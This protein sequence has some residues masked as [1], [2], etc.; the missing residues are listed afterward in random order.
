MRPETKEWLALMGKTLLLVVGGV[1]AVAAL[2]DLVVAGW[3]L[4]AA[5]YLLAGLLLC[6]PPIAFAFRD[7]VR[8]ARRGSNP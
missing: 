7:A 1:V 3:T 6:I 4:V 2:V 5:A 8:A